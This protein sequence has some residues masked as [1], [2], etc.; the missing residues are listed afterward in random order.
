[1]IKVKNLRIGLKVAQDTTNSIPAEVEVDYELIDEDT[2][3]ACRKVQ[4]RDTSDF[5]L[6]ISVADFWTQIYNSINK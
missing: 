2:G 4:N 1:M 6:N 5:D 3:M